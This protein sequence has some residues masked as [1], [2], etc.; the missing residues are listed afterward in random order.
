L[1]DRGVREGWFEE[2]QR[3]RVFALN[4]RADAAEALDDEL[5]PSSISDVG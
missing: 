1:G 2:E 4:G 3:I 5:R